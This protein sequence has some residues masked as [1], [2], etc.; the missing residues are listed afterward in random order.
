MSREGDNADVLVHKGAAK[1]YVR[2]SWYREQYQ[3]LSMSKQ[4]N[5]TNIFRRN[6][7][8]MQI[9]KQDTT[10]RLSLPKEKD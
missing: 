1:N 6:I 3:D 5:V 9:H 7:K 8:T 10:Y 2:S 4:V